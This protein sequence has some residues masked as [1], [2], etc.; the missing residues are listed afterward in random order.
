MM[1]NYY[2]YYYFKLSYE[3]RRIQIRTQIL[4][5]S[6]LFLLMYAYY[7]NV[8]VPSRIYDRRKGEYSSSSQLLSVSEGASVA[9]RGG[10]TDAG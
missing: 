1:N 8:E 7:S 6:Q 4:S 10:Q 5:Q 2:F 3:I 9:L